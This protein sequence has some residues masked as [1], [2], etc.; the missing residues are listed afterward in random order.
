MGSLGRMDIK[1]RACLC[2]MK[3][4]YFLPQLTRTN[5][6]LSLFYEWTLRQGLAFV[7]W[8]WKTR[9]SEASFLGLNLEGNPLSES[10]AFQSA[11]SQQ[12]SSSPFWALPEKSWTQKL[13]KYKNK[14]R[15]SW[16]T[17]VRFPLLLL[18]GWVF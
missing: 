18:I 2:F 12:T 4:K 13:R 8:K 15:F 5:K 6:G 10:G 14:G 9:D 17:S 11:T 7:L 16:T 1:T 3:V